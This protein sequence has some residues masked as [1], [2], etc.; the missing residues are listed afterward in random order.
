MNLKVELFAVGL[1]S[2]SLLAGC[3]DLSA[4]SASPTP[5]VT[6]MVKAGSAVPSSTASHDVAAGGLVDESYRGP[7]LA[8]TTV[9]EQDGAGP[10]LCVGAVGASYP[11]ACGGPLIANWDWDAVPH[12]TR[13]GVRFGAYVV[14]GSFDGTT[15]TLTSPPE[16]F[17]GQETPRVDDSVDLEP[18]CSEPEGGWRPTDLAST[19][20]ASLREA[21]QLGQSLDGYAGA[22]VYEGAQADDPTDTVLNVRTTADIAVAEQALREVW[23]GALC[24]S[25]AERTYAELRRIQTELMDT[26]PALGVGIDV[27]AGQVVLR[28][29]VA[30]TQDQVRLDDRY[31]VDVVRLQGELVPLASTSD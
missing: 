28:V 22:W 7:F 17:I 16:P 30:T 9:R 31:G 13:A 18:Q 10:Q 12:Q 4:S 2:L 23:G 1:V 20:E 6:G 11:P 21:L 26:G 27:P 19:T 25:R 14:E 15:F 5:D 3:G 29:I 8:S 24:V